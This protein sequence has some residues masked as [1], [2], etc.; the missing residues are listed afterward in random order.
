MLN[1]LTVLDNDVSVLDKLLSENGILKGS[2]KEGVNIEHLPFAFKEDLQNVS[3]LFILYDTDNKEHSAAGF[4]MFNSAIEK[5]LSIVHC[6]EENKETKFSIQNSGGQLISEVL[7]KEAFDYFY[8]KAVEIN[9]KYSLDKDCLNYHLKPITYR[10]YDYLRGVHYEDLKPV[11]KALL[12]QGL[13]TENIYKTKTLLLSDNIEY[14]VSVEGRLQI[15]ESNLEPEVK[16]LPVYKELIIPPGIKNNCEKEA[17]DQLVQGKLQVISYEKGDE[18]IVC[19]FD[20]ERNKIIQ[21]KTTQISESYKFKYIHSPYSELDIKLS[22]QQKQ[23]LAN[24]HTVN[25]NQRITDKN[26]RTSN[27]Q[28]ELQPVVSFIRKEISF[29]V[30][31]LKESKDLTK[32]NHPKL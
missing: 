32:Q 16:V 29:K 8:Y 22:N 26:G 7:D 9:G 18:K 14:E 6:Q 30:N 11:D 31:T 13:Q 21:E 28:F 27:V 4:D 17:I 1:S 2:I 25:I 5:K 23:S 12:S 20:K 3:G 24:L 15:V 10:N 19:F